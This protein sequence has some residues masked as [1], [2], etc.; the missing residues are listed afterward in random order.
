MRGRRRR[1][2]RRA[3]PLPFA[4]PAPAR[5]RAP[6][7]A[8]ERAGG[9][10]ARPFFLPE[11]FFSLKT[12]KVLTCALSRD[13]ARR[14]RLGC[15]ALR[16]LS[17]RREPS[18][19]R[20]LAGR[21]DPHRLPRRLGRA[22]R[23][24]CAR[25][26]RDGS[27]HNEPHDCALYARPRSLALI[28]NHSWMQQL[29]WRCAIAATG[30]DSHVAASKCVAISRATRIKTLPRGAPHHSRHSCDGSWP[31]AAEKRSFSCP[32]PQNGHSSTKQ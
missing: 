1:R 26:R 11:P 20:T 4:A 29:P 19:N 28:P 25:R 13:A 12:P 17:T 31:G 2:R 27:T 16:A 23:D 21:R 7:P 22:R 9:G 8:A 5:G 6:A 30:T 32:E 18:A 10:S 15:Q 24:E 14:R 3:R